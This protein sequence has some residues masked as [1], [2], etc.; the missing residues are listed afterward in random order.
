MPGLI[1]GKSILVTGGAGF[2][3]SN[4]VKL[5]LKENEV[6]VLDNF[7]AVD[8]R[9]LK[10]LQGG[11]Q[12][13]IIRGDITKA[14]TFSNLQGFDIIF[15]LA[16]NSDVKFGSNNPMIDV[17]TNDTGTVNVLEFMRKT[18][19]KEIAFSSSS[20]VYGEAE[21]I[22]TPESYG[23]YRPI[24]SYGASKA[25]GEAYIFAYSHYYGLRGSIFRFAN[26]V[27]TNSTHGVI[28]DFIH[29]LKKDPG[30]LEILGDGTQ[31]KSYIHVSDCTESMCYVHSLNRKTDV[32]NLGNT[33]MTRVLFI[34][35]RICQK[36][37]LKDVK[38]NLVPSEGGRGWPGDVKMAQLSI[39]KLELLGWKNRYSSDKAVELSIDETLKMLQ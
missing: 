36:M 26:V 18:D 13:K 34:A 9:F 15:H 1:K 7:S 12:L 2:I 33:S 6:T 22:P 35:D 20:T 17:V 10:P 29:K 30:N 8:D 3:G 11:K 32:Y 24:S 16:A 21:I 4:L 37:G 25:A 27:G 38:Y 19:S 39:E 14:G 5:L 23:P 31:Q 28:F